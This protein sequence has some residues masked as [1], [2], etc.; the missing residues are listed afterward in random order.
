MKKIFILIPLLISLIACNDTEIYLGQ[1]EPITPTSNCEGLEYID[2]NA[3]GTFAG[4]DF[5]YQKAYYTNLQVNG[6]N[7]YKMTILINLPT[8]GTCTLPEYEEGV[9]N[10]TITFSLNNLEAQTINFENNTTTILSFNNIV[11]NAPSVEAANCGTF[12]LVSYDS[13]ANKVY[14]KITVKSQEGS[15]INGNITF[16]LC[17]SE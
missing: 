5:T 13:N 2:Q 3:K 8:G 12:E 9:I 17:E 1:Q 10:Q 7:L 6:V 15:S 11:N 4:T 14:G 16:D